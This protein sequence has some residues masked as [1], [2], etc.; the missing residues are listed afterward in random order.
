MKMIIILVAAT[1]L[2]LGVGGGAAFFLLKKDAAPDAAAQAAAGKGKHAQ[3]ETPLEAGKDPIYQG[4]DPDFVVAFRNPQNV[5]F[6]KASIEVMTYDSSVVD[7]LKQ[8]MPAVRDAVLTVFGNQTEEKLSTAEGKEAFR[9]EILASI[10]NTLRK[11]TGKAGVEA[12]FF[13][14]YVM[15]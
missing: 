13:S 5:R 9:A 14:N 3:M 2:L 10:R 12:V 1:V 15:Q 6:I 11:Y 4:L 8:N 7:A